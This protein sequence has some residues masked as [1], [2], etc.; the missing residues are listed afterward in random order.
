MFSLQG[1]LAPPHGHCARFGVVRLL[2]PGQAPAKREALVERGVDLS[3]CEAL[4]VVGQGLGYLIG[5]RRRA[6]GPRCSGRP[7]C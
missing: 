3:R 7:R 6:L 5:N 4:E 1:V 2:V